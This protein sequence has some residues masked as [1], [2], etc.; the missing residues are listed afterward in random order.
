VDTVTRQSTLAWSIRR[1]LCSL[2]ISQ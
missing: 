1:D 2:N